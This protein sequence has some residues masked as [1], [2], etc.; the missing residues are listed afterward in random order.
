MFSMPLVATQIAE[1]FRTSSKNGNRHL[2]TERFLRV[3]SPLKKGTGSERTDENAVKIDGS[4]VPVPFFDG[5]LGLV[6]LGASP[7]FVWA[8]FVAH[9]TGRMAITR[10]LDAAGKNW[11]GGERP[12]T[13]GCKQWRQCQH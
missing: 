4:E 11:K 1:S 10:G 7:R 5:L 13:R 2:A 6:R 9:R 3:S 8:S 12:A